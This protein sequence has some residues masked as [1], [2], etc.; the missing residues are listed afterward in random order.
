MV[1]DDGT[2]AGRS[3]SSRLTAVWK[4][5]NKTTY[6]ININN[7]Q[8][9]I[10]NTT[11]I[12][13]HYVI[14]TTDIKAEG[15]RA[16]KN[17]TVTCEETPDVTIQLQ[18]E[19]NE[20]SRQ[21]FWTD[22]LY[23]ESKNSEPE[24][25]RGA[26]SLELTGSGSFPVAI[27]VPENTGEAARDIRLTVKV[28]G[29]TEKELFIRQLCPAWTGNVGWE[30]IDD[31]EMAQYGFKWNRVACYMYVYSYSSLEFSK[32]ERYKEYCQSVINENSASKYA[33][34]ENWEYQKGR[35]GVVLAYRWYIKV[36]Y[37]KLNSLTGIAESI[38]DGM[39]NTINLFNNAGSATTGSFESILGS[40]LK[41]EK[42]QENQTAFRIGDGS[43]LRD[44]YGITTYQAPAPTDDNINGSPAVGNC[45]KK[46]R[47]NLLQTTAT[48]DGT[49]VIS[50]SPFIKEE[51]IFWYLPAVDQFSTLPSAVASSIV[52]GD[53]WSSTA[54]TDGE[55]AYLGNGNTDERLIEHKVRAVRKKP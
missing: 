27:F 1:V 31:N 42:G 11:D 46:N 21:G 5:G 36:D 50:L 8:F 23:K 41:T 37:S 35:L 20:Y 47:Y 4:M 19:M 40:I 38:L 13:A 43:S 16:D 52:P 48:V 22:K 7:Y 32:R 34:V 12:D 6:T 26:K 45:L 2:L 10:E 9:S 17:W 29:K 55:N 25:A 39:S 51:D 30:Q 15:V 54:V 18:S 49:E 3:Y 44:E 53:C 33:S 24:S 14:L 28:D